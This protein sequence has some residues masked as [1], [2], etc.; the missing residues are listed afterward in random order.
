MKRCPW[1]PA[2]LLAAILI[3]GLLSP[4]ASSWPDGLERVAEQLGFAARGSERP[5][6][7]AVMA[8]YQAP[9]VRSPAWSTAVAG[10]VGTLVVFGGACLL[11][12]VLARRRTEG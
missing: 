6:V 2:G 8:E 5:P 10:I 7:P 11:G 9:L 1:W 4:W 3:A 12:W